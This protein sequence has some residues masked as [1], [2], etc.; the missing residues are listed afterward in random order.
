[1]TTMPW[2]TSEQLGAADERAVQQR[3]AGRPLPQLAGREAEPIAS[4]VRHA[5]ILPCGSRRIPA[6]AVASAHVSNSGPSL[7]VA[8]SGKSG[9]AGRFLA[10]IVSALPDPAVVACPPGE[11]ERM[12]A[13]ARRAGGAAARAPARAAR[14]RP[15]PGS[16]R[17][18]TRRATRARSGGSCAS[19]SRRSSSRG[20]CARH[21]QRPP[22][23]PRGRRGRRGS[24]A[25]TTSSPGPVV[26]A[27]AAARARGR[28]MR[29]SSTRAP[30]R[31]T[32]GWG[33]RSR[34]SRRALTSVC[35]AP[36]P[37]AER[38]G[39]LWLGAIVEW[40]RPELAL[41]VAARTPDVRLRLA[42]A[43]IDPEGERLVERLIARGTRDDL[44]GRVELAG[45][46]EPAEALRTARVLLHT[47]ERE[48][49][50][51]ALA[52]ALAS[53]VPVVAPA[54][55]GP[56]EIVDESCGRLFPPGDAEAAAA[57]L[58]EVLEGW[59]ALA[60]GARARA[61]ERFDLELARERF[62]ELVARHRPA[63][64]QR[65]RRGPRARDRHPRLGRRAAARSWPPRSGTCRP[66]RSWSPTAARATTAS[67][68]RA[69]TAPRRSSSRT[70]ATAPPRTPAS[71]R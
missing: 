43:P 55:G 57:A 20:A 10:D 61:E 62:A 27:R 69:A 49:F 70:S 41:E 25:I 50:G 58:G 63:S 52:E 60:E 47:A 1:M 4:R 37:E 17:R 65:R 54:A 29:S 40:K 59:S 64:A 33:G 68:S 6:S 39:V 15:H 12:L 71:R 24:R 2:I 48:P 31:T 53:G 26:G 9:G 66:R 14:R 36:A 28:R 8:Y 42:G 56:A 21:S 3:A 7:F 22:C 51:I 5:R 67:T 30:S 11:L 35:F 44:A 18:G 13:R 38:N 46:V 34:S 23:C 19:S 16:G 32:C 45:P